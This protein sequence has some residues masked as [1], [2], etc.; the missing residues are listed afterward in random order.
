MH[1]KH[2]DRYEMENSFLILEAKKYDYFLSGIYIC[3]MAKS[4]KVWKNGVELSVEFMKV[5]K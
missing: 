4:I 2:S 5:E 3:Q 1:I